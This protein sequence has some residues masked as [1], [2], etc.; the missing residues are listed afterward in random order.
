VS[1][2]CACTSLSAS[3]FLLPWTEPFWVL[4]P[5]GESSLAGQ[6]TGV[7]FRGAASSQP[8]GSLGTA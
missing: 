4:L 6:Q 5:G 7:V 1:R 2:S 3:T 8:G